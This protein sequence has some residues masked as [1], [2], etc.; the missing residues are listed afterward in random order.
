RLKYIAFPFM[1]I[2][3][4]SITAYVM[5][6][7]SLHPF[8]ARN[9]QTHFGA[10]IFNYFGEAYQPLVIGAAILFVEWLILLWMYSKKIF[11][12]V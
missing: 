12:R 4:N 11:V 6:D 5:A 9:L 2:G 3:A 7:V 8:I 10:G 1:V